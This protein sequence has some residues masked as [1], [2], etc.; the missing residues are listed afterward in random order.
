MI[1][2]ALI[3]R[4]QQSPWRRTCHCG[5]GTSCSARALE[6]ALRLGTLAAALPVARIAWACDTKDDNR[7]G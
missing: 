6:L 2:A 7:S 1:L 4:Y 5:A 3:R